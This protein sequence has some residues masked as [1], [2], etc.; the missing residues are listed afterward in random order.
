MTASPLIDTDSLVRLEQDVASILESF[1][2][3]FAETT[4]YFRERRQ[5]LGSTD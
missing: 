3:T 2:R 1:E 5:E 4:L